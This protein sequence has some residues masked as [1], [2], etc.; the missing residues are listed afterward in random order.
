MAD[1]VLSNWSDEQLMDFVA[2]GG[3]PPTARERADDMLK[4]AGR[5]L[6][7]DFAI[8]TAGLPGDVQNLTETQLPKL[9]GVPPEKVRDLASPVPHAPTSA[10]LQKAVEQW[11]GPLHEPQTPEGRY[12]RSVAGFAPA[13]ITGPLK[14]LPG[15]LMRMGVVPGMASQYAGETFKGDAYEVPAKVAAGLLSPTA[16]GRVVNPFPVT[17]QRQKYLDVLANEGFPLTAYQV[18]NRKPLGWSESTLGDAPFA[19]SR[20]QETL[21]GQKSK[22]VERALARVLPKQDQ[23]WVDA[24]RATGKDLEGKPLGGA[25][26][27]DILAM[28]TTPEGRT[29]TPETLGVGQKYA[30]GQLEQGKAG[31]VIN[32]TPKQEAQLLDLR[33]RIMAAGLPADSERALTAAMQNYVR[34]HV[35][36]KTGKGILKGEPYFNLTQYDS[37]LSEFARSGAPGTKYAQELRDIIEGARKDSAFGPGTASGSMPRRTAYGQINEGR[38]AYGDFLAVR[39]AAGAAEGGTFS[40]AQLKS[41]VRNQNRSAYDMGRGDLHDLAE[42]ADTII[43]P[44]PNSGTQQRLQAAGMASTAGAVG[45][46]FLGGGDPSATILGMAGGAMAQPVLGRALMNPLTQWWLS[47]YRPS[48]PASSVADELARVLTP[49]RK[50]LGSSKDDRVARL[51]AAEEATQPYREQSVR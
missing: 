41:A 2:K 16:F 28:R 46:H 8:G 45:A 43:R 33:Q 15:R 30:T 4:S 12:T 23:D 17:Q 29:A 26:D 47:N 21:E 1:P 14:A 36:G 50:Q 7:G 9:L 39:D 35:T 19:G 18:T 51:L 40:P 13:A 27:R 3:K 24:V 6:L 20:L 22:L 42:A 44:L 5:G 37:D 25:T 49:V 31:T 11:T 38:R 32:F 10:D 34:G 48:G